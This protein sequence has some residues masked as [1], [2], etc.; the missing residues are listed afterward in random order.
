M[1]W[2]KFWPAKPEEVFFARIR[3]YAEAVRSVGKQMNQ[4]LAT[5]KQAENAFTEFGRAVGAAAVK[6]EKIDS[7][8]I[9]QGA[10]RSHRVR[11]SD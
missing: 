4:F 9:S 6:A 7:P 10:N 5:V 2:D 11:P 1:Q 3:A 8:Y